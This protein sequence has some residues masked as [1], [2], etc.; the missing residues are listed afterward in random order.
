[1]AFKHLTGMTL[2]FYV[3]RLIIVVDYLN[4]TPVVK[5]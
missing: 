1:M 3:E 2:A 5:K 4:I